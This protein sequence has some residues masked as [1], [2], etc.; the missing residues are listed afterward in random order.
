[1]SVA[2]LVATRPRSLAPVLARLSLRL[3]SSKPQPQPLLTLA[4]ESS[5]D[6]T[7]VTVL[8]KD[9][10]ADHGAA[11]LLFDKK[12]TS[13]NR[14]FR[15]VCPMTAVA[16]HT[17][18]LAGMLREAMRALPDAGLVETR[19]EAAGGDVVW[20]DGQPRR[21]PDFVTVTRGPG[22]MS[23]LATGLN[24]AK[25]LAVAWGVPLLAVHH[26][27]AHALTPRLV[28]ALEAGKQK[29]VQQEGQPREQVPIG[30]KEEKKTPNQDSATQPTLTPAFPFLSLLVSGGHSLLVLSRT[31]TNHSILAEAQNIAIGD[32]LDKCARDIIPASE[33]AGGNG[34]M[35]AAHLE[36]FAFPN[37]PS[38]YAYTPPSTRAEEIKIYDPGFGWKLTPPLSESVNMSFEFAGLNG[39][40][41]K[42]M[43][44]NPDMELAERR[45]VARHTMRLAFEHLASR[46]LLALSKSGVAVEGEAED[47]TLLRNVRTLVVAGGV[48]SNRYLMHILRRILDVR[49]YSNIELV[50]PPLPLCT[51]NG[52]MIAWTGMEMYEAGWRS[53]LDVLAIRKWPLDPNSENGGILGA[54][55]WT[56]VDQMR[57]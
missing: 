10:D 26:M 44:E 12:I 42:V 18:H 46:L 47:R 45:L 27:Q 50:C 29:S 48:A 51:D 41:I 40:V 2:W 25:G 30:V 22:M 16:S 35:Y 5:C 34:V 21:K 15:G 33:L 53:E 55:G 37:G 7:C 20:V 56:N 54:P 13:D 11:R 32:M 43:L 38:D 49:G 52:A 19:D 17:Q 31:L 6:D 8:E 23:N 9:H 1:M 28:S 57:S 4:I 24:T 36:R 14:Q 3:L 39:Q